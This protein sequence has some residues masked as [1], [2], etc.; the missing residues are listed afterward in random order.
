VARHG[1]ARQP[2]VSL[3]VRAD[4][5]APSGTSGGACLEEIAYL[6]GFIDREQPVAQGKLFAKTAYGRNL[7]R[8]S[9]E[10]DSRDEAPLIL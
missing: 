9:D 4:D 7:L 5:P 2:A 3:G 6:Q 1:H 10:P 8:L